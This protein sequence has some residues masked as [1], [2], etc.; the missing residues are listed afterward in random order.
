MASNIPNQVSFLR[1]SRS[2]PQDAQALSVELDKSYIDIANNVNS[3]TIGIFTTNRP[4]ITGESFYLV[5]N[6]RQQT[7]RQLYKITGAGSTAH[8]I[9][10]NQIAGF[11]R[12]YGTYTDGTNW[13]PIGNVDT[14]SLANQVSIQVTPTNI[15]ITAGGSVT[16]TLAYVV[17][18]WLNNP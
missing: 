3:R 15:V 2:F 18:E 17:L 10:L 9:K 7:Q 8:G 12:I 1:T 13:Y 11:T 5:A 14:T 16:L 4:S 6:Q